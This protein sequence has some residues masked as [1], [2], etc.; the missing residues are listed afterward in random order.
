[1]V[2]FSKD[3]WQQE[4]DEEQLNQILW[5]FE[6]NLTPEQIAVYADTKFEWDQME[7]IRLGLKK[8]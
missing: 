2:D 1:M 7:Q 3:N 8:V 6:N 4:F 5:G